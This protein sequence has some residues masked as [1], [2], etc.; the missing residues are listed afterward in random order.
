MFILQGIGRTRMLYSKFLLPTM[1]NEPSDM[2]S[3]SQKLMARSGMI[4]KVSSGLFYYL[5]YFNMLLRKVSYEIRRSMDAMH[6]NEMKFPILVSQEILEKTGRWTAFGK[7]MFSLKDR[8]G[9]GYAISPTNEEYATLVAKM[10]VKSYN[11]LPFSVYQIQQKHR[12]EIRPRNGVIR[13]REFT[14]KDAYSFHATE[15]EAISYYQKMKQEYTNLFTRLGLKTFAVKADSG[16]MGGNLCEEF[17]AVADEGETPLA[18]CDDCGYAANLEVVPVT[19]TYVEQNGFKGRYKKVITER[20]HTVKELMDMLQMPATSFVKSMVYMADDKPVVALVRGDRQV[21][22][23]KLKN[24]LKCNVLELATVKDIEKIGSVCGFVGPVGM[25]E[26]IPIFADYEIM[27]MQNFVVGGNEKDIHLIDVNVKDFS[28]KWVDLR[29]AE[30]GDV[31]PICGKPLKT[32]MGTELGH[33]F[34]LG[35]KYTKSLDATFIDNQG[36]TQTL[37]G[38]CY[39]IG[40]ERVVASMIDQHHD[41]KGLVLPMGVAPFK[42]DVIVVDTKNEAQMETATMLY[43]TLENAGIPVLFDDR[44]E[45][46]GVKFNDFELVGIPIKVVCG[47]DVTQGMVEVGVRETG[48]VEK[49]DIQHVVHTIQNLI[50]KG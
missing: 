40:L 17:M 8:N 22:E 35:Q 6:C 29:F 19:N 30:Q 44:K 15:D 7:E 41:E 3:T 20:A 31:C 39:G 4:R 42:V 43:E 38:G 23:V 18:F 5:P 48:T 36:K 37:Y 10:F 28:C 46:V 16:A 14:M 34:V 12:D 47:R 9:N 27:Q 50:K 26:D 1:K 21:N 11:D 45:R 49:V 24:V 13:A 32:A 25:R 33:I 2:D